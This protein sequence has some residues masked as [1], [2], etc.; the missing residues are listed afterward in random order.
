MTEDKDFQRSLTLGEVTTEQIADELGRRYMHVL[1]LVSRQIDANPPGGDPSEIRVGQNCWYR[2]GAMAALG[3]ATW[4]AQ[5][6][7]V[8][9]LNRP[10]PYEDANGNED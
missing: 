4:F 1:V 2:N 9:N 6:L 8:G 7:S 10:D 5:A 3:L